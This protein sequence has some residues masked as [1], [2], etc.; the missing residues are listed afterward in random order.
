MRDIA[1]RRYSDASRVPPDVNEL[2]IFASFGVPRA[3]LTMLRQWN[4]E[5]YQSPQQAVNAIVQEHN[6]VRQEEYLSLRL[7]VPRLATL[8]ETGSE[9]LSRMVEALR[10]A[11]EQERDEKQLVLGLEISGL[12]PLVNRMINLLIEAGLI[13]EY[14]AQVSHGGTDRT[15]RRFTPHLAALIVARAFSE[16]SRGS[17]PRQTVDFLKRSQTKHPIRRKIETLLDPTVVANLRFDLPVCQ[18][19]GTA[20]LNEDQRFCH[21]CGTRLVT[22]S[23]FKNC[24]SLSV[25][26]V[27]QLTQW[28]CQRLVEQEIR[29]IGDLLTFQDPG[30]ELRKIR[31][32]GPIRASTIMA[33]VENY[34]DEFLS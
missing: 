2:L 27:P 24:M 14:K 7:K 9:M 29:T 19:C 15:Y 22:E 23:T 10:V 33:A 28:Q 20:R 21:H 6:R 17:S 25:A 3:Y 32:V 16:K 18:K 11:N 4:S 12:T 31:Q 30:T 8:V 5:D 26:T 1:E 34:V 13:F